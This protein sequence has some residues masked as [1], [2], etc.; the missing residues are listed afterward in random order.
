MEDAIYEPVTPDQQ[1]IAKFAAFHHCGCGKDEADFSD[2]A[3]AAF[4]SLS[5]GGWF[6][7]E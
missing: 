2:A 6:T 3:P 7:C 4:L 1:F 5:T